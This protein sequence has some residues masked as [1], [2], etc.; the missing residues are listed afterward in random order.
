[1]SQTPLNFL[2]VSTYFKGADFLRACKEAGNNVYLLTVPKLEHEP[3]PRDHIDDIFY[4]EVDDQGGWNREHVLNGLAYRFRTIHFDKFVALDDFDVE[5]VAFLREYFRMPG[6]GETTARYF[7][8]KLA[9]RMKAREEGI[10]VPEFTALFN[11]AA[12][13]NF[14][15]NVPPPWLIKPRSEASA[16]GIRKIHDKDE[17]WRNLDELGDKRHHCLL[18]R[19]T[20]GDVFH[21]DALSFDGKVKFA[22][23]SQY[24]DAPFDVAHGGG[25]FRSHTVEQDGSDDKALQ[26]LTRKVMKAFGMEYSASHTEFIKTFDDGKYYFLETSSRVG[27][28]NLSDMVEA[29]SGIN[30]WAEWAR[31]ETAKARNTKYDPPEDSGRNAGIVVS[32]SRFEHPDSS[33]FADPEIVWRMQ[34]AWHIGMVVASDKRER[35][36]EL[37]DNHT[38]RIASDFHASAPAPDRPTN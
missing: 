1:M 5:K 29:A 25:I 35:I 6:M 11:D 24:L 21:V 2:C 16:T 34:K 37:L 8:D 7:R 9:M 27:G 13:N 36:L 30:L 14:A 15:D 23:V 4:F 22:R 38:K 33:V 20:P 18:E 28:A 17:L 26:K 32:L 19:F 12:I 3:W 10:N 31:L